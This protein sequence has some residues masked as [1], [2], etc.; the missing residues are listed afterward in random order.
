MDEMNTLF[1]Y[2]EDAEEAVYVSDAD[3]GEIIYMDRRA[4]EEH[5]FAA[6]DGYRGI[7]RSRLLGDLGTPGGREDTSSPGRR[8]REKLMECGGRRLRIETVVEEGGPLE[9]EELRLARRDSV[10]KECLKIFFSDADPESSLNR[11]LRYLGETF[12]GCRTYI[13]EI[14]E[15]DTTTNTYEWCAEGAV[16]QLRLLSKIPL[17]DIDYWLDSFE[18]EETVILPRLEDIHQRYPATYSLLK[19]QGISSLAAGPILEDGQL[20]GFIG[21]DDPAAETLPL[22]EQVLKEL[23]GYMVP[24][25][26]RRDLYHRFD[27]MSYHDMLTGA[28]NYN[29]MQEHTA[30][31]EKWRSVGVVY[32]SVNALKE[33]VG[34]QGYD[35]GNETVRECYRM[36]QRTMYTEWIYRV[37]GE[38]FVALYRDT[39]RH[40][41][42]RDVDALRLAVL[43]STCQVSIGSAW[44]DERP[45]DLK[46]VLELA[47][48]E[49]N[50]ER[51]LH[52]ALM[53]R[54]RSG[55]A[56]QT[57]QDTYTESVEGDTDTRQLALR[58]FLSNTY[59]DVAFLLSVLSH[60]NKTSY[61]FFGDM[62][63]SVYYIS[64][65]MRV[66][67]GFTSNI[68]SDLIHVWASRIEDPALLDRFWRDIDGLLKKKQKYH[69]LRYQ[70]LDANENKIWIRCYGQIKWSADGSTPLFFAG[71]ITQQDEDFV[72]DPLTNFPTEAVLVRDL[73]KLRSTKSR[74]RV[75]GFS[76]RSLTQINNN[77][78]R[79]F[80]DELVC[81]ISRKLGDT[82]SHE[83][84]FYRL[85]GMRFLGL[86]EEHTARAADELISEIRDIVD[87][88]YESMGV[89]IPSTCSFA[90]LHYPQDGASP[91][92]LIENVLALIKMAHQ[93]AENKYID[94]SV[95]ELRRIRE[96]AGMESR[97]IENILHDMEGFRV[98]IQPVVS[99]DTGLPVGGETLLR[100]RYD[101][102]EVS[103]AVFVPIIERENMIGTVGRWVLEQAVRACVRLTTLMEDFYLTVNVSLRQLED[104]SLVSYI[105]QLLDKYQLC[106][107]HLVLEMTE[108]C[109]DSQQ[110][111][112]D[113]FVRACGE[114]GIR[115][116]LD[117]FGTGYSSLRVLLRY[118]SHIVK[119]DRS[120]LLEMSDSED[121]DRFIA[122]IVYA[123]HQIGKKVCMEGVETERQ[124]ELAQ[125]AG[126]DLIQGFYYYR[127][128]ELDAVYRLVGETCDESAGS[129][130]TP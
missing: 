57:E 112:L 35:A 42:E 83:V 130:V 26:K 7:E 11:M 116:A 16:S 40:A 41:V 37:G 82:L 54:D 34:A 88:T 59:C 46:K 17:T 105:G 3:T 62:Q 115:I 39:D 18:R 9:K 10:L 85:N 23:G 49:M 58:R 106:G 121:K 29:A 43:Q 109:M 19:A 38:G 89:V 51:N 77:H 95:G 21:V 97:L 114:M 4:R 127:P 96:N 120:L 61:F 44:S 86:V 80:G 24:Q 63:Q 68:V 45:I 99:T 50:R 90:L 8:L 74:V 94:G 123:C 113:R 66:K 125:Q 93:T 108:S 84:T 69:D 122:S 60:E 100:W 14:G 111:K 126:C 92:E 119:L 1:E 98:V 104:D 6:S 102:E 32:C 107:D 73:E 110:E 81:E 78:G 118:P 87:R 129:V 47:D 91:Q 64:E 56:V 28:Y 67:F 15:D 124:R 128:M 53:E 101:G 117:D 22:L 36:M 79:D 33:T 75:I 65:N 76:L 2:F 71:R 12:R 103:P 70:V 72:V 13:F 20:K 55:P 31:V 30:S 52:Y 5:G 27:R 48:T 25:F